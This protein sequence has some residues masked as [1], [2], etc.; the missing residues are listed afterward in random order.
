MLFLIMFPAVFRITWHLKTFDNSF[1][2][3]VTN[4]I[5]DIWCALFLV[6]GLKNLEKLI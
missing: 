1:S 6:S 5:Y 3:K 2:N 4:E